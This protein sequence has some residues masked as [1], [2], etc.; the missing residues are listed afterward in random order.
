MDIVHSRSKSTML[1]ICFSLFLLI[2]MITQSYGQVACASGWV[3]YGGSC[4]LIRPSFNAGSAT[5]TWEQCNAYCTASYS[6]AAMFCVNNANENE[7]I[8]TQYQSFGGHY[9]I[10]Y[11]DMSPYGGGQGTK[12][13]GWVAGCTSTYTKWHSTQPD[14]QLK[15]EDYVYV[16]VS[17]GLWG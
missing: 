10:G 11:T 6:G 2:S 9:W 7:W 5:G 4:Y 14:N 17:D 15:N 12:V 13:F 3:P 8:R 1:S 16:G